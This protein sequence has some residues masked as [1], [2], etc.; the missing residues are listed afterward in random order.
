MPTLAS[1]AA[2]SYVFRSGVA[3]KTLTPLDTILED[4]NAGSFKSHSENNINGN[5]FV[6]RCLGPGTARQHIHFKRFFAVQDTLKR[7][8]PLSTCQNWKF[9]P[10]LNWMKSV[11]MKAWRLGKS[12]SVDD[13]TIGFQYRHGFQGCHANKLRSSYKSEGDGFQC[14]AL[15]DSE[16][17]Y[18]F[19]FQHD[20]PPKKYTELGLSPLHYCVMYHFDEVEDEYHKCGV[21]SLYMPAKFCKDMYN[22]ENK[23]KLHGVTRNKGGR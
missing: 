18:T 9:D 7:A 14:D 16:Y 5:D 8:L 23:I 21:D 13:Q 17:T 11:S 10:F 6:H 19:Y 2:P 22:H 15:C 12:V 4:P 3:W 20:P 1:E